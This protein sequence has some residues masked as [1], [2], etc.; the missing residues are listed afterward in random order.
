DRGN[1][2]LLGVGAATAV[3]GA[4]AVGLFWLLLRRRFGRSL[5]A[6]GLAAVALA[7]GTTTWKYGSVLYSH[8][9][10]ALLVLLSLYLALRPGPGRAPAGWLLGLA[11]GASVVVEYS[12][13]LF[14]AL[15]LLYLAAAS[16]A[17]P[18]RALVGPALGLIAGL[19]LPLAF[20]ALYD[21]LNFGCAWCVSTFQVDLARWP[22]AAG[23]PSAFA[24][25][26]A[27]GLAGMLWWGSNNQ[28]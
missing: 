14:V 19:A 5:F 22:N 9:L 25:P 20:L 24:T 1:A 12:N 11:L 7:L 21:Q 17:T 18:A 15:V 26:L 3:A 23:M 28:G 2:R 4:G 16:R 13:A 10:S 6:S 27:D 8:S